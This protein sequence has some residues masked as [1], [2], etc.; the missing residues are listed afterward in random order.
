[1]RSRPCQQT[2]S[3]HTRNTSYDNVCMLLHSS[4]IALQPSTHEHFK[5]LT[6]YLA[7]SMSH[8]LSKQH[9]W[10]WSTYGGRHVQYCLLDASKMWNAPP[11]HGRGYSQSIYVYITKII[12]KM[13]LDSNLGPQRN[14]M[15]LTYFKI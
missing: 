10:S 9:E 1:M 13:T 14:F 5:C 3:Y 2:T 11:N 12:I 6:S 15:S 4:N 8:E 7:S